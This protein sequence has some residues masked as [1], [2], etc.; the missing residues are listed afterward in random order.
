MLNPFFGKTMGQVLQVSVRPAGE[1][2]SRVVRSVTAVARSGLAGDRHADPLSPRQ[3]LLAGAPAYARFDLAAQTLDENLLLDIDTSALP[4]G[5]LLKIGAEAVLWLSFQCEP[6]GHLDRQRRGLSRDI[7]LHRGI[8]AR[9]LVGG[10]IR[11]GDAVVV[12]D[13]APP[14]SMAGADDWR[15]RVARVLDAV[16]EGLVIEFRQLARLS[17]V[18]PGYCRV[19]PKLAREL[20]L[21]HKAVAMVSRPELPR[22]TGAGYFS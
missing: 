12:L 8:M 4:P 22:W 2:A 7:G 17:G 14:W 16:P 11:P 1:L 10:E 6:C 9:V 18:A 3:V 21:S 19:F 15:R 5:G 13:G 20:G